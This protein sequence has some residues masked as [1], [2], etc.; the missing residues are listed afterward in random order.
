M[1]AYLITVSSYSLFAEARQTEGVELFFAVVSEM[2][3]ID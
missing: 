2:R 3:K 1:D